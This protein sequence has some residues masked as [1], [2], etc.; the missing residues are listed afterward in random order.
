M[1]ALK[2]VDPLWA[3]ILTAGKGSQDEQVIAVVPQLS[4][5]VRL[6]R[7]AGVVA[8]DNSAAVR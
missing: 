4:L 1:A 2:N 8:K 6:K 3:S 5:A 7:T